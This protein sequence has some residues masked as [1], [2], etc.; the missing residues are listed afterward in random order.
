[1]KDL[2]KNFIN[3]QVIYDVKQLLPLLELYLLTK[4]I[5]K[6]GKLEAKKAAA[7][8]LTVIRM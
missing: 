2:I 4:Q 6:N 7:R 3:F 1:M 8:I 5:F